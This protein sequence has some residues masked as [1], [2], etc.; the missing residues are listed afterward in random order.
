MNKQG[1]WLCG[2]G[3]AGMLWGAAGQASAASRP[4]LTVQVLSP[5]SVLVGE[6][7]QY[8]VQVRNAGTRTAAAVTVTIDLPATRTSPGVY[9]MGEL[10]NVDSRCTRSA[11]RLTC[12]VGSLARSGST[13]VGFSLALPYSSAPL[14]IAARA[15]TSTL[16]PNLTNNEASAVADVTYY[17]EPVI[18]PVVAEVSHCTGTTALTSFFECSLYPSS[19]SSHQ[20][21]LRDDHSLA[22]PG[23]APSLGGEW[24]QTTD[25]DLTMTYRDLGAALGTFVGKAVGDG[26]FEGL[27]R[28]TANAGWVSPYR[29]CTE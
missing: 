15:Q 8:T 5:A 22:F 14:S 11:A 3:A 16:E 28:F 24:D 26:C 7:A 20:V 23:E 12:N 25:S 21:E 9:V 27:M 4:D 1:A 10:S 6:T 19:L 2:V 13:N 18:A 29:V 17:A